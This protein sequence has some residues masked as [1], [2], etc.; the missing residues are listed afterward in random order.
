MQERRFDKDVTNLCKGIAIS[1]VVYYHLFGTAAMDSYT[2]AIPIARNILAA[3]GNGRVYFVLLTGYAFGL[4]ELQRNKPYSELVFPRILKLYRGYWLIFILMFALFPIMTLGANSLTAVYG[5]NPGEFIQHVILDFLGLT[6][7]VYGFCPYTLNQTWWYISLALLLILILPLI[8]HCWRRW[9]WKTLAAVLLLAVLLPDV[10]YMEYIPAA[11]LGVCLAGCNGFERLH[12]KGNHLPGRLI[13]VPIL[14]ILLILW[15]RL[16]QLGYYPVLVDTFIVWAVCQFV[17]DVLSDIPVLRQVGCWVGKHSAN[18]F[19]VHSFVCYYWP[20]TYRL[21]HIIP[22]DLVIWF[23]TMAVSIGISLL[24][25]L[26]RKHSGYMKLFERSRASNQEQPGTSR[27]KWGTIICGISAICV[28]AAT[29]FYCCQAPWALTLKRQIKYE[30]L[31]IPHDT[32]AEETVG[33]DDSWEMTLYANGEISS[34]VYYNAGLDNKRVYAGDQLTRL[35]NYTDGYQ[36]DFPAGTTFD[37]SLSAAVI[38][39]VGD[40][41]EFTVSREYSPY[42]ELTD[43]MA[44]GLAAYAPDFPYEDGV[45]QYIGYYQSRFLL[46]EAWQE[47]NHVSVSEVEVFSAGDAKAYCYHA[48]IDGVPENKYDAYSYYYIRADGQDFFR[49]VVK[50]RHEDASLQQWIRESFA[51]FRQFAPSGSSCINTDY[52]PV[53]PNNWSEETRAVYDEIVNGETLRWG[54]FAADI[55]NTGIQEKIPALETALEYDFQV[56]LSY[57]HSVGSF[58]TEFMDQNWQQGRI[59]ELTYQLTENNNEDMFGHSPLLDLYRGTNEE[60]VREFARAAK[61]FGHPF[62]FRVCNEMNSDWTSYGGVVN[63]ADP[64]VFVDVYRRIYEIFQEEGVDNCI[65]IYNPNDRNA[66]PSRWNDALN[67]YPGNEYVQMIGVTGYNN[68]T[69]YRKWAE[70]WREF[71]EIYNAIQGEYGEI[72]GAFPWIITEFASS[73]V[74]G[75]KVA[76]IEN[77]FAHIG[78]Y[79]NIKIAV[80]FSYAD[81]DVDGTVARPYWLDETPDTTEAFRLGLKNYTAAP[82]PIS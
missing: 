44:N 73:S 38:E 66:P 55:Y 57:V 28:L 72:F 5:A 19:Y 81:Y 65:W 14:G 67:Y 60:M 82:W 43:E 42:R 40:G 78:N 6:H 20:R 22:I 27:R 70:S 9:T 11:T 46:N 56:V 37:F 3:Y 33:L 24:I 80:W 71:D 75:D 74:G 26:I 54:I 18:I 16:R 41:Y 29:W 77:M 45:D 52:E 17:F 61:D 59:V 58:P 1:I 7:F 10:K 2:A 25:E 32:M 53:L 4:Q 34:D 8:C 12:Q 15:Y 47:N 51:S 30:L 79:P 69:Y 13:R 50:Y 39:G 62:L 64:D 36:M 31:G 48:V 76:W 35:V 21:V 63:M 23:M 49:I 68:G